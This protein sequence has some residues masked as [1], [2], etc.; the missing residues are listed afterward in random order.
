MFGI[1]NRSKKYKEDM[2]VFHAGTKKEPDGTIVTN[3]GRVLGVVAK[4]KTL[5]AAIEKAYDHIDDITFTDVFYRHDI[6]RK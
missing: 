3:G 6:G 5:D 1:F 4:A 2:M